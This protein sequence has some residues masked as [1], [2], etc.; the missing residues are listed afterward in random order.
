MS[1]KES[2][3]FWEVVISVILSKKVYIYMCPIPNGF[4]DRV[5]RISLSVPKLLIRKRYYVLFLVPVFIVQV[6][7]FV[8]FTLYS[9]D[10]CRMVLVTIMTGS[11]LDHWILLAFR[12]QVLL[13][14]LNYR[15][16]AG[17]PT[18]QFTVAHALEF[19]VSTSRLLVTDLNTN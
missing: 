2:S 15:A 13:I 14:T 11:S 5:T 6:T 8:Q 4:R 7:K 9:T 1:Q 12:L 16:L 10:T 19:S 17:S 3:I 18:L